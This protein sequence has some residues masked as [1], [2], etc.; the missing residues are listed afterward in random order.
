M[1]WSCQASKELHYF[2]EG[3]NY[4]RLKIRQHAF[5]SSSRYLSGYFDPHAVDVYFGD[6]KKNKGENNQLVRISKEGKECK[7]NRQLML[8]LSTN[9]DAVAQEVSGIVENAALFSLVSQLANQDK[10][11]E[12][13]NVQEKVDKLLSN[14]AQ[15]ITKAEQLIADLK[16]IQSN[17]GS[18]TVVNNTLKEFYNTLAISKGKLS[19]I[20]DKKDA[21][22]WILDGLK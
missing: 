1:L 13:A 14:N 22:R 12:Q 15:I 11:L 18:E 19:G 8:I 7:E 20:K 9:S 6:I 16:I 10:I 21:E 17:N 3:D 5:L 4:Y 2:K